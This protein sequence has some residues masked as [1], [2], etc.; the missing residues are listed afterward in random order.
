[1]TTHPDT[2]ALQAFARRRMQP[3]DMLRLDRHLAGCEPC[4]ARLAPL[5][6]S[7]PDAALRAVVAAGVHVAYEQLQRYVDDRLGPEP[8]A[9]IDAHIA[10]CPPCRREL[11]DLIRHAPALRGALAPASRPRSG[12][13]RLWSW[14]P[15]AAIAASVAAVTL[16]VALQHRPP[17]TAGGDLAAARTQPDPRATLRHA[18]LDELE[19]VSPEAAAAWRAGDHARLAG[20]LRSLADRSDPVALAA[21]A[22]LHAQGLG[23]PRDLRRAEQLWQRAADLGRA[24]A[25]ANVEAVRALIASGG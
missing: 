7:E 21:L 12:F 16:T 9:A 20:L 2:Q 19:P 6:P 4:R 14:L 22:S 5:T 24:D 13:A 1:M 23:V 17:G 8:R 15:A 3:A 10:L 25:K 18:A 11:H